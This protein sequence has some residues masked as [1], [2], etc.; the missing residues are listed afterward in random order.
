MID[1][2]VTSKEECIIF[3]N[4]EKFL[5]SIIMRQGITAVEI[6]KTKAEYGR[7]ETIDITIYHSYGRY[8]DTF[9]FTKKETIDYILNFFD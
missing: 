7:P 4:P 8:N 1:P 6:K 2:K 9:S 5:K 3:E